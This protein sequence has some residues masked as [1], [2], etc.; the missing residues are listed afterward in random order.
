MGYTSKYNNATSKKWP[1]ICCI[2]YMKYIG[3][4]QQILNKKYVI[5]RVSLIQRRFLKLRVMNHII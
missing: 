2:L 5:N 1:S 3:S 4:F